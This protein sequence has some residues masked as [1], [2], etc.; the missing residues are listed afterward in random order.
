MSGLQSADLNR[1]EK[2][3]LFASLRAWYLRGQRKRATLRQL[4]QLRPHELRDI[5]I[6]PAD[7]HGAVHQLMTPTPLR[8]EAHGH[9][10]LAANLDE[11][12]TAP[13]RVARESHLAAERL[14]ELNEDWTRKL[15][16]EGG[17]NRNAEAGK[18]A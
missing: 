15:A 18:A 3:G 5:G 16:S 6:E 9:R 8:H 2:P 12:L 4:S 1:A 10:A 17:A 14:V 13:A 11:V 7:L